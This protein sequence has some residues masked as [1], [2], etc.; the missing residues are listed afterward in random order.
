MDRFNHEGVEIAYEVLGEGE[1]ILLIHG[2]GSNVRVNWHDTGWVDL[3]VKNGRQV[4]VVDN[5]G[6][7]ESEKL[8]DTEKYGAHIMAEDAW[9]LIK[10]LGFEQVDVM[11]YSMGARISAFLAIQHPQ[12]VRSLILSGLAAGL[13]TGVGNGEEIAQALEADSLDDLTNPT[14]RMF[15]AFGEATKSDL[16][17]LAACMRSSR[18]KISPDD[19]ASLTMPCLIVVGTEDQIAGPI[20]PILEIMPQ[21]EGLS[22]PGRDHMRVVGDKLYKQGVLDFLDKL[23]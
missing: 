22:I 17:A 13:V 15:R 4:I 6:H 5:R 9:A 23:A 11:G 14:Q 19:L 12:Y 1:P 7:G 16:K 18:A 20:E 8:Y 10:H 2:F 21:A 3:L